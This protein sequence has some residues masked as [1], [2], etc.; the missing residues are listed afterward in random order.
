MSGAADSQLKRLQSVQNTVTRLVSG[1]RG[2]IVVYP[3]ILHS[4]HF[5]LASHLQDSSALLVRKCV[6]CA[7]PAYL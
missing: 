1:A 4:L 3:P 2:Y 7:V 6:H 5:T